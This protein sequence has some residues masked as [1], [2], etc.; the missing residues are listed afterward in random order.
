MGKLMPLGPID[1]LCRL[2]SDPHSLTSYLGAHMSATDWITIT[3]LA[4]SAFAALVAA[5]SFVVAYMAYRLAALQALTHPDIS[6]ESSST[7]HRSLEFKITRASGNADWVVANACIRGN[8]RR[9]HYLA[10]GVVEYEQE[11]E[12]EIYRSYKPTGPW[13]RCITF[14]SPVRQGVSSNSPGRSRL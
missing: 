6:W 1:W 14:D 7:G 4:L 5:G 3:S 8:W 9:R 11:F 12:G 10:R 2:F 13:Q